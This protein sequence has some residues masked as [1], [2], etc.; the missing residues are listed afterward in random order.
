MF[1]K[2]RPNI[3][4]TLLSRKTLTEPIFSLKL[5][6][7]LDDEGE[8]LFGATNSKLYSSARIN[9]PFVNVTKPPFASLWTVQASHISFAS[10]HLLNYTL[11]AGDFAALSSAHPYLILPSILAVNLTAAIG[12][13][14][15]PAWFSHIPC[16]RRQELP[17]LT[18]TLDGHEVSISALEYTLEVDPPQ[19]G[20]TCITTFYG[21]EELGFPSDW[22]G[23][24]LGSPFLKGFYSVWDFESRK[25]GRKSIC[26]PFLNLC[27][28]NTWL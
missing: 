15:A 5:P 21:A 12:A 27:R 4:S 7:G 10:P 16:E 6:I 13:E 3:L 8:I 25:I 17:S 28:Q 2:N 9:L 18:F 14:S 26:P 20:R 1:G 11:P 24:M 23:M 19:L 22:E